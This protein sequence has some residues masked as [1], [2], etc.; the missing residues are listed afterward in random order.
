M[1]FAEN[2]PMQMKWKAFLGKM[3]SRTV[4]FQAVLAMI[5]AFLG[6]PFSAAIEEGSFAKIWQASLG[7]WK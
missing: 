6:Q 3:G 4:D 1:A 2:A 5:D 7:E